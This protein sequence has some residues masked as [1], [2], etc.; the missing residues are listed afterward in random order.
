MKTLEFAQ[1][2]FP[3]LGPLVIT[4]LAALLAVFQVQI[5]SMRARYDWNFWGAVISFGTAVYSAATFVQ[6]NAVSAVLLTL[7]SRVQ[8]TMLALIVFAILQYSMSYMDLKPSWL[9][10]V[11]IAVSCLFI[12]LI[13]ATR[14]VVSS[15]IMTIKYLHLRRP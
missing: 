8:L 4:A 9:M 13:W 12:F 11:G 15:H 6:Y 1:I 2:Y 14:L 7:S 5:Y 10:P 3:S